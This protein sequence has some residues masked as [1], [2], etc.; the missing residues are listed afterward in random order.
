MALI[1]HYGTVDEEVGAVH[2]QQ[3][4]DAPQPWGPASSGDVHGWRGGV[5]GKEEMKILETC[6]LI[7][8]FVD[9]YVFCNTA[10]SAYS[11]KFVSKQYQGFVAF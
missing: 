8:Y 3:G 11:W 2:R 9:S 5:C 6:I 1:G 4:L 7:F 10:I